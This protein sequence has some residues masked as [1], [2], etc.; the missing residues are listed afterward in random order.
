MFILYNYDRKTVSIKTVDQDE[1]IN[2]SEFWEWSGPIEIN[3][4]GSHNLMIRNIGKNYTKYLKVTI[5]NKNSILYV[6]IEDVEKEN[7]A[8]RIRNETS[9]FDITVYQS[10]LTRA[11]GIIIPSYKTSSFGLMMPTEKKEVFA[12]FSI[13][14]EIN[15][16]VFEN[17]FSLDDINSCIEINIPTGVKGQYIKLFSR[18]EFEGN[19]KAL[20]FRDYD[21][22]LIKK[23]TVENESTGLDRLVKRIEINI[24]NINFSLIST[25][26]KKNLVNR[27]EIIHSDIRGLE[28]ALIESVCTKSS[29]LRVKYVNVDN[30]SSYSTPFP[31]LCTPTKPQNLFD[32]SREYFLDIC[33]M[34]KPNSISVTKKHYL[35]SFILFIGDLLQINSDFL[36]TTYN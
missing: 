13:G 30:N 31:V 2:Q 17:K 5:N 15:Y 4:I 34:Q 24:E 8:Y 25:V 1:K 10:C 32:A 11:D 26:K 33:I 18:V 27:C 23:L 7:T 19:T 20:V 35:F 36:N 16:H 12:D 14:N 9:Q 28:F 29:Q 22:E 21:A 6:I 3:T